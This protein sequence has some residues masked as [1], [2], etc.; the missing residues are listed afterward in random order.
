MEPQGAVPPPDLL[1]RTPVIRLAQVAVKVYRD[2]LRSEAAT[3]HEHPAD[4]PTEVDRLRQRSDKVWLALGLVGRDLVTDPDPGADIPTEEELRQVM[5]EELRRGI[6]ER[7]DRII[8]TLQRWLNLY[9]LFLARFFFFEYPNN[10][11]HLCTTM[12]WSIWPALVV[13]W[14]VC[15]MFYNPEAEGRGQGM[16][17]PFPK[18]DIYR[19]DTNEDPELPQQR[20][21][22]VSM[23][24]ATPTSLAPVGGPTFTQW[25]AMDFSTPE[26]LRVD[27]GWGTLS[28]ASN[29]PSSVHAGGGQWSGTVSPVP[30]YPS[31]LHASGGQWS[32]TAS[33]TP[34]YPSNVHAGGGQWPGPTSPAAMLGDP[35]F[36]A[37]QPM[38]QA[39]MALPIRTNGEVGALS[40]FDLQRIPT[41]QPVQEIKSHM[42]PTAMGMPLTPPP[43]PAGLGNMTGM[44]EAVGF[45]C[46][47]CNARPFK[48]ANDLK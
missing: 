5:L 26:Q 15:W 47:E 46:R 35:T 20:F 2:M 28:P 7:L 1:T 12:P 45:Q 9:A 22:L 6:L 41:P 18:C 40:V 34:N 36:P 42:G 10:L 44:G 33:P 3:S 4:S 21:P 38:S 39:P 27:T 19:P 13:L 16:C 29:Y 23:P 24:L 14:G 8:Q 48:T 32:G 43:G 25:D 30:N 17:S 37:S 31:S 11:R